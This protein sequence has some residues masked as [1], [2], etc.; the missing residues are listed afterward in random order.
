MTN[1]I[2]PGTCFWCHQ[3][4]GGTC[5]GVNTPNASRQMKTNDPAYWML[6]DGKTSKPEVYREGCY[7]CMD[8]EFAQM[9]L[10]LCKPCPRCQANGKDGHI[11]ADDVTCD[12]CGLDLQA[13]YMEAN[14]DL[15]AYEKLEAS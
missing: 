4:C 14:E 9:G 12:D 13:F 15:A 11:A 7:I 8:P 10:P 3:H 2:E 5:L 1:V 6:K